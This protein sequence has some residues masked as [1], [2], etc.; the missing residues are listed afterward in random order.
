VGFFDKNL[1]NNQKFPKNKFKKMNPG[2]HL[3]I[4]QIAAFCKTF[5]SKTGGKQISKPKTKYT[6]QRLLKTTKLFFIFISS[7]NFLKKHSQNNKKK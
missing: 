3:W 4:L 6:L 7:K 1:V 5:P 2:F